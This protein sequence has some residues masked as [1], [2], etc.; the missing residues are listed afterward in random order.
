MTWSDILT[1][2]L[3]GGL[4]TTLIDT[5]TQRKK[6]KVLLEQTKS[7]AKQSEA[8]ATKSIQDLYAVFSDMHKKEYTELYEKYEEEKVINSKLIEEKENSAQEIE[9]IKVDLLG[10]KEILSKDNRKYKELDKKY[11][12]LK[13]EYNTLKRDYEDLDKK[14]VELE[15]KYIVLVNGQN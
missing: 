14:Y 9:M 15:K 11:T 3:S 12:D 7:Q 2:I 8:D 6:N 10:V 13:T 1:L 4:I 5:V